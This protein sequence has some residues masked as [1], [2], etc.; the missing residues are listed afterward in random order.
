MEDYDIFELLDMWEQDD[1]GFPLFSDY[2]DE[3]YPDADYY[4]CIPSTAE[5]HKSLIREYY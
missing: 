5:K 1:K 4:D 2:L 3:F